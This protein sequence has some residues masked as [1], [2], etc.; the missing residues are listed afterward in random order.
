MNGSRPVIVFHGRNELEAQAARDVLQS[1]GVPVLHVPSLSAGIFGVARPTTV[2][3]P[4]E[5]APRAVAALEEAGLPGGV[6]DRARGLDEFRETVEDNFPRTA[7]PPGRE[8]RLG[9]V[10]LWIGAAILLLGVIAVLR[11]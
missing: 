9:Q 11:R 3:V 6:R 4:E 8:T 10:V 7:R 5:L 1:A 2:A